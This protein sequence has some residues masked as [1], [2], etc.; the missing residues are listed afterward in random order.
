MKTEFS[1]NELYRL[2]S[3]CRCN[4]VYHQTRVEELTR[5]GECDE[6]T[7]S[8]RVG[9]R[10]RAKEYAQEVKETEEL[11]KKLWQYLINY[12]EL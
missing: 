6:I 4:V 11:C 7:E 9:Y 8:E 2:H 1:F 10:L 5:C 12:T 3:A